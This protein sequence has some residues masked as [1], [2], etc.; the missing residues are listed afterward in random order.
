[1]L[2][3]AALSGAFVAPACATGDSEVLAMPTGRLEADGTW[4]SE[5]SFAKPYSVVRTEA[6]VLPWVQ[7]GFGLVRIMGVKGFAGTGLNYAQ[8]AQNYGDYKDK[9]IF[10]RI[11]LTDESEW[12]PATALVMVDPIGTSLFKTTALAASKRLTL[13]SATVLDATVGYGTGRI[14]GAFGGVKATVPAVSGLK[15]LLEKDAID[16]RKDAYA[17]TTGLDKVHQ[18]IAFG[19]E[20]KKPGNNWG[21]RV[22]RRMGTTEMAL[23]YDLDTHLRD[24]TPKLKELPRFRT[25][26]NTP[27]TAQWHSDPSHAA[28]V[29]RLLHAYGFER[30]AVEYDEHGVL[31]L[32]V[33]HPQQL[34]TSAAVG[35]A[36]H[37][38]LKA[39]PVDMK[40]IAV[41][42]RNS[43][44][45][46]PVADYQFTD[47]SAL[48][49]YLSGLSQQ[50][51]LY[52]S[53]R[54]NLPYADADTPSVHRSRALGAADV[55]GQL[56][57]GNQQNAAR[58]LDALPPGFVLKDEVIAQRGVS[59]SDPDA[60]NRIGLPARAETPQWHTSALGLQWHSGGERKH[61]LSIAPKLSAYL[62]GPGGLQYA[63][64]VDAQY[65][66][67]L[68][69]NTTASVVMSETLYENVSKLGIGPSNSTQPNVRSRGAFYEV[70]HS[71]K[72]DRA[73][74]NRYA[75][76]DQGVYARASVGLYER[77]YA[78]VGG[79]VLWAPQ[80][81]SWA[82]DIAVDAVAQRHETQMFGLNGYK[83]FTALASLHYQ[84]P[85]DALVTVR[86]GRFLAKDVGARMEFVRRFWGG[87]ELGAWASVT[88]AKDFG[89]GN[90]NYR[91]KGLLINIPFDGMLPSY[92]KQKARIA[93][94][95]WTRDIAQM[96]HNP[97]DLY[98]LLEEDIY[99]TRK[100]RGLERLAGVSDYKGSVSMGAL[101]ID[102]GII[103]P[104]LNAAGS[105]KA[106]LKPVDAWETLS[107]VA[108]LTL[109]AALSDRAVNKALGA[110]HTVAGASTASSKRFD[111]LDHLTT[112]STLLGLGTSALWAYDGRDWERSQTAL[113][114]LEA[115]ATALVM[116]TGI[117]YA[118]DRSRPQDGLGAGSFGKVKRSDSSF[119]SR[120]TA[121]ATAMITPYALHYDAPVLYALPLLT[122]LARV[123]SG[124]HWLSDTVAGA[125]LGYGLGKL[126]YSV[127]SGPAQ[128]RTVPMFNITKNSITVIVPQ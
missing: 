10:G 33:S 97:F 56:K 108:V 57:A 24:V 92:S 112:G 55:I 104:A 29:R 111:R 34:H 61:E 30:V 14:H 125:G 122:G 94:A 48:N 84:L 60:L 64:K 115:S 118:V 124:K 39:G 103:T 72:L 11:K 117:K 76:L 70:G 41:R 68:A 46:L 113:A 32:S 54:V 12:M 90:S 79:Q 13:G 1:L 4:R 80:G 119:L 69:D 21:V 95:P 19:A 59:L 42:Y 53:V 106:A 87:I 73:M 63:V 102:Q 25:P 85:I 18:P 2:A 52:P 101:S 66:A 99:N 35:H 49:A 86:A 43:D 110:S 78:G 26:V 58:Q 81:E 89:V 31:T 100:Q 16:Y 9:T 44:T 3:I 75:H 7:G 38:A 74:V 62:N 88:N 45:Q 22:A 93:I 37:I 40:E 120:H 23:F 47:L 27:T 50:E 17:S 65:D 105:L 83:T 98:E 91:D 51:A 126:F 6:T 121:L 67:K 107:G 127:H 71:P 28:G 96:I 5:F 77:A 20:Y 116:A 8:F 36:V 82:A 114:S 123:G 15:L 128:A 109:T